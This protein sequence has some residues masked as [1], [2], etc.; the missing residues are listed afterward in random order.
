[1]NISGRNAGRLA[2]LLLCT[3]SMP[4]WA[5]SAPGKAPA[6]EADNSGLQEIVVTARRRA[7]NL[8]NVP[9]AIA[10]VNS[11]TLIQR[12]IQNESDLQTAV[13]GLIVH[14]SN[15]QNQLNYVI[16]GESV[17]PYSGS[18]PGVQP[19]F[20]D[21]ALSGNTATAFYDV[22]S[23]QVLKGPQGTLFGRNSTGG[24]V[25]YQST[26]PKDE[27]GGYGSIQYGN[28][29]RFVA[30]AALNVPFGEKAAL[31]LAGTYQSGG[32][33]VRN[34]Y[35]GKLLGDNKV[36]S[37]RAT[38]KLTPVEALTNT[39]MVQYGKFG[40]TNNGNRITYVDGCLNAFKSPNSPACWAVPGNA[41]YERLLS[42]PKGTY[43]P[44]YPNGYV[45]P[46]GLAALPGYLDSLGKYYVDDDGNFDIHATD[47][48]VTNTT[49]YELND[50]MT[51]KNVFG[52]DRTKRGFEYDNDASPYPFLSAG[53]GLPGGNQLET[54]HTRILSE[55][56]QLQGKAMDNRLNYV[57]GAF[58]SDTKTF[59][60]S[61]IQGFGY[62]PSID[63]PYTFALRYKSHSRDRS[64]AFFTQLTY[65]V[66]DKFNLTGGI[67]QSWD[68]LSL[69]QTTDSSLYNPAV[70]R[71]HHTQNDIS[72]TASA[73]YH[74]TSEW[75]VYLTT[76]GSWRVGGYNPF[77]AASG[78]L[79][80]A[81]T[82]TA[83]TGGTYFPAETVR[84]VE[85]GVKFNGRWG[86]IPVRLNAD[87]YNVWI[88]NVQKTAYGIVAGNIT[89]TTTTIPGAQVTGFEIDGEMRP[90]EWLRVGANFSYE[91]ARYTDK[92]AIAFGTLNNFGP[93]ADAPKYSGTAF[94]EI[95]IPLSG[96]TGT[97]V[98]HG[99]GYAQSLLHTSS[100]G[101]TY[102]PGDKIPGYIL[103]NGRVDWRDPAGIKGLT[104]SFFMKNI[105]AKRYFIGGGSGVQL[106]SINSGVY[107]QPRTF[108]G[109][110]RYQF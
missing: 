49:N 4:L 109:V 102:S 7:E 27:F 71:L 79:P 82:S 25:L 97:V 86:G 13:P 60:N 62:I 36:K 95:T 81:N 63:Y 37:G 46:G 69:V 98:I 22:E 6:A 53:G 66:T 8:S 51:L 24:A 99:D 75:M 33:Y 38:L 59:N 48:L 110:L 78:T 41:F 85:G 20:N 43:F 34:I 23:V 28:H 83:A 61:P 5:Q 50:T 104:A 73:D 91:N 87:V 3:T 54:R 14:A 21:V 68:K 72:W 94:G 39:L 10:A 93:F 11:Q 52:Y 65:A 101:N 108:G 12:G 17:E 26:T 32:A 74:V 70:P 88:K 90:A 92:V 16:R 64:Y 107:G 80:E 56:L 18:T 77:V 105:T 89:S 40:G 42:M 106:Y 84:D 58:Y 9:T 76:R 1:M 44:N 47:V 55:E 29:K 103:I 2:A 35:N 57:I 30:E 15:N 31:R 100:L 67:R 45:Y 96:D 19:Y